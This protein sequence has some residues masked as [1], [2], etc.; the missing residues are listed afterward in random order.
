MSPTGKLPAWLPFVNRIV[1]LMSRLDIR[2]DPVVVLTVPGRKSGQPRSTPVTPLTVDGRHYVVAALKNGDWARNVRAAGQG[3]IARGRRTS[4]VTIT[5]VD[6]PAR[7]LAVMRQFPVKVPRGVRFF[8]H[9]GL[10]TSGDPEQFAAIAD[11]VAV[12]EIT[13]DRR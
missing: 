11:D 6:D 1:R 8:V 12:F 9:L 3:R 13:G 4:T 2:F 5:E 7:R 10:V